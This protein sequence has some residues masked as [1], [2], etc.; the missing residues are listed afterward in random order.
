MEVEK[1]VMVGVKNF[2][3]FVSGPYSYPEE[4]MFAGKIWENVS[5]ESSFWGIVKG[6][7]KVMASDDQEM[8]SR[9]DN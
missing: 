2:N 1:W 3:V 8:F 4:A 5:D 6:P 7:L 9:K